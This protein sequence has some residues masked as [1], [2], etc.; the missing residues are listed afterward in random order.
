M[1]ICRALLYYRPCLPFW[2]SP[3]IY[4]VWR[5][6]HNPSFGITRPH[7]TGSAHPT[8][9]LHLSN[10]G[11]PL[12]LLAAI[13]C[14][15][16]VS[17]AYSDPFAHL[18]AQS[19]WLYT[20]VITANSADCLSCAI[21]TMRLLLAFAGCLCLLLSLTF[22]RHTPSLCLARKPNQD[23]FFSPIKTHYSTCL[24]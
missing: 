4:A 9:E 12:H 16:I 14:T 7:S 13:S 8:I 24:A 2:Q 22:R 17:S 23:T 15:S 20:A 5:G 18:N 3:S 10:A 11:A 19:Y 1:A 21:F 6:I